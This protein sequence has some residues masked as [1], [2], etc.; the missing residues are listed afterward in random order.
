MSIK[1]DEKKEHNLEIRKTIIIE[2]SSKVIFEAITKPDELTQW[3]PDQAILEA[4]VGGEVKFVYIK[5]IHPEW[6]LDRDYVMEGTVVDLVPN[7]KLSY[8]W[9]YNDVPE[10]PETTVIWELEEIETNKTRVQLTHL[11]FTGE[12]KGLTSFESHNE[13][14]IEMLNKLV[15]YCRARE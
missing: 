6:K 4:K 14:W 8:T 2:A 12:E 9:K 3:F 10:F 1:K 5:E 11:G 13:G 7:K 15:K